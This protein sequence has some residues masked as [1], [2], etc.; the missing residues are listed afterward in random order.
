MKI[1][2]PLSHQFTEFSLWTLR[3]C[4]KPL[5]LAL[6]LFQFVFGII[7]G[8]KQ[9]QSDFPN[10]YTSSKLITEGKDISRIYDD[11]W[12]QQQIHSYNIQ[13][14]GKFSPFPP[15]TALV[16]LPLSSLAPLAAQRVMLVINVILLLLTALVFSKIITKS[17]LFCLTI[18]LLSGIGLANNF[19]LGQLYLGLLLL[20][21]AGYYL[22]QK[23]KQFSGGALWGIGIAIKYFPLVFFPALIIQRKWRMLG[24]AIISVIVLNAVALYFFGESVYAA[25]FKDV[26][27][28]HLNGNLS[29]QSPYAPAFQSWNAFLRNAFVFDATENPHPLFSSATA[30]QVARLL[31]FSLF[32]WLTCVEIYK[33]RKHENKLPL[34]LA[35]LATALLALSPASA[36][37]H[38]ILLLFPLFLL[39]KL[40][41]DK[42]MFTHTLIL[43]LLFATLNFLP[44]FLNKLYAYY[45]P[46]LFLSFHRL[47]LITV[48]YGYVLYVSKLIKVRSTYYLH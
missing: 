25:F 9:I 46:G 30:F 16:M 23:N 18:I 40:L 45:P 14:Q 29:S 36:S 13:Q 37:Y 35:I 12:F 6:I 34:T 1:I 32:G 44:F 33:V 15:P 48:L 39:L 2:K 42:G 19:M 5:L 20:I 28:S 11:A 27:S 10:Y 43:A 47:W 26:F 8:W 4:M 3:L 22:L 31:I 7:P 41:L 21:A 38:L 24:G 17:F